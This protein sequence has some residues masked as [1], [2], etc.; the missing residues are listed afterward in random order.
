MHDR[1]QRSATE[2]GFPDLRKIP[3]ATAGYVQQRAPE[4]AQ[5]NP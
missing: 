3:A 2:T 4:R 1:Q 5:V